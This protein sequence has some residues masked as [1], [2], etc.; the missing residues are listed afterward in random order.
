MTK[1][2]LYAVP[3]NI[4]GHSDKTPLLGT[5]PKKS[6]SELNPSQSSL[7]Y[8]KNSRLNITQCLPLNT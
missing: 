6:L 8:S 5:H 2:K 7:S 1:F 4:I 3:G